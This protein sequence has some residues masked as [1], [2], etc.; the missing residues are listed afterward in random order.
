MSHGKITRRSALKA[1][2]AVSALASLPRIAS[3]ENT[4]AT[5]KRIKQAVCRW[6]Y[7]KMPI[8]DLCTAAAQMGLLGIDLLNPDEYEVPRRHG[9]ICT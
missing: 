5:K 1:G 3:G 9:L 8:D 2:L 4:G 7:Q 6:C